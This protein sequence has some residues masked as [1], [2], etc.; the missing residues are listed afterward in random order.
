MTRDSKN[1]KRHKKLSKLARLKKRL[2]AGSVI[3]NRSKAQI[4]LDRHR[5]A[6][7]GYGGLPGYVPDPP[8]EWIEMSAHS[9]SEDAHPR[10]RSLHP[11]YEITE[12]TSNLEIPDIAP[13]ATCHPIL[14]PSNAS[15]MPFLRRLTQLKD[16]GLIDIIRQ[17]L[18]TGIVRDDAEDP[19]SERT[20]WKGFLPPYIYTAHI[21]C[22][23]CLSANNKKKPCYFASMGKCSASC[24][25]CI[26]LGKCIRCLHKG[27]DCTFSIRQGGRVYKGLKIAVRW[28]HSIFPDTDDPTVTKSSLLLADRVTTPKS[29]ALL[30]AL[31]KEQEKQ[32]GI[33]AM[34]SFDLSQPGVVIISLK[35]T[36]PRTHTSRSASPDV[37]RAGS[38][39]TRRCSRPRTSDMVTK[40]KQ[41]SSKRTRHISPVLGGESCQTKDGDIGAEGPRK[42]A[43]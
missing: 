17:H 7:N 28:F 11:F 37:K 41:V 30:G 6:E 12:S 34:L 43:R 3:E 14:H 4:P 2:T 24:N 9:S 29:H 38:K 39:A 31:E 15:H 32:Q 42:R 20:K 1:D 16:P 10:S 19:V 33:F 8:E 40:P 13:A 23:G 22:D 18:K 36:E 21:V 27:Q 35:S 5:D 25:D 26:D